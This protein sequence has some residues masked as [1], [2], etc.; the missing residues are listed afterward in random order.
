MK[1]LGLLGGLYTELKRLN[2]NLEQFSMI[3]DYNLNEKQK[4]ARE[5]P[6]KEMTDPEILRLKHWVKSFLNEKGI[7]TT[8]FGEGHA[9]RAVEHFLEYSGKIS[10]AKAR[11]ALAAVLDY[12]NFSELFEDWR[13][14]EGGA[15]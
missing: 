11:N 7:E 8:A 1:I 15:A 14:W 9:R 6:L 3:T 5:N 13:K 12:K 2:D 10:N 4:K